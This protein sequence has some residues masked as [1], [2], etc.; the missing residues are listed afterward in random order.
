[1]KAFKIL[2]A[3][4]GVGL[5]ATTAHAAV[6]SAGTRIGFDVQTGDGNQGIVTFGFPGVLLAA[7]ETWNLTGSDMAAGTVQD[8]TGAIVNGITTA[9]FGSTWSS[10]G[11]LPYAPETNLVTQDYLFDVNG[12]DVDGH[13]ARL[14]IGGLTLGLGYNLVFHANRISD[15]PGTDTGTTDGAVVTI[16]ATSVTLPRLTTGAEPLWTDGG[17]TLGL[18]SALFAGLQPDNTGNIKIYFDKIN[19]GA[20]ILTGF[21]LQ[22]V[23]VPEPSM[24]ALL[25]LGGLMLVARRRGQRGKA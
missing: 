15:Q 1:M 22:A 3:V 19:N 20:I 12:V 11:V 21:E 5:L 17:F 24:V 14:D 8:S 13:N 23:A 18:T 16:G 10:W 7:G 25:G 2:V 9:R 4:V 6:I